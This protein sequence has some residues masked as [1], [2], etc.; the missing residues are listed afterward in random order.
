VTAQ[1]T[2]FKIEGDSDIHLALSDGGSYLNA[3]MPAANCLPKNSRARKA[4]V[5]AH[6][7]FKTGLGRGA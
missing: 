1:V 2:K 4:I 3:E 7:K 5:V 6:K